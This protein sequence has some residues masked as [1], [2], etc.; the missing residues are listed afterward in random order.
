MAQPL[1]FFLAGPNGAGKSTLLSEL[2]PDIDELELVLA[3]VESQ[4][5]R[6]LGLSQFTA[7]F[8]AS[9]DVLRRL[10]ELTD[11]PSGFLHE[12]NL[13]DRT[14]IRLMRGFVAAGY[15]THIAFIALDRPD[16]AAS[17]V[18]RRVSEG[19]HPVAEDEP[20][21]RR[22]APTAR[23]GRV[24]RSR[25][26]GARS[27]STASRPSCNGPEKN[28]PIPPG[29]SP[30]GPTGPSSSERSPTSPAGHGEGERQGREGCGA[31]GPTSTPE[32]VPSTGHGSRSSVSILVTTAGRSP[33][34]AR[35]AWHSPEI[36]DLWPLPGLV[37]SV[38]TGATRNLCEQ[39]RLC[40]DPFRKAPT[41]AGS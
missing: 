6:A 23:S 9:R 33:E 37:S 35:T 10:R 13:A 18:A 41:S 11:R 29:K 24:A 38:S 39:R 4:A 28:R 12:T 7:D 22:T 21:S 8:K 32:P 40:D 25:A 36:N 14:H 19:G 2:L 15:R 27:R 3:D 34:S 30:T 17:R 5:Y 31:S 1:A 20:A 16:L 26:P